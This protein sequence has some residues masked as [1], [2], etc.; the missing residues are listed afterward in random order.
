MA[1]TAKRKA[2]IESTQ[3]EA[4]QPAI[5]HGVPTILVAGEPSRSRDELVQSLERD[6]FLVLRAQGSAELLG[7]VKTHSR[8]IQI[9]LVDGK[10]SSPGLLTQLGPYQPGI[11]V[12]FEAD[13]AQATLY[14]VRQLLKP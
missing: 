14:R 12:L 10:I 13:S 1:G 11:R 5:S 3:A 8:P 2:P 4:P 6:G 9:L 7:I